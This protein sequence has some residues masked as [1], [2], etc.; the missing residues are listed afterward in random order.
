MGME[1]TD[2]SST[3]IQTQTQTTGAEEKNA[4]AAAYRWLLAW[5]IVIAL[6]TVLNKTRAGHSFLYYSLWLML[7][8]LLVTQYKFIAAALEPVGQPLPEE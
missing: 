8:F 7:I 6:A 1:F 2:F 5:A 3:S 4:S